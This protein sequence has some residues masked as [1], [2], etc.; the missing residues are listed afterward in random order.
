M[1]SKSNRWH[2]NWSF[3]MS[4]DDNFFL[5][6]P[7]SLLSYQIHFWFS[8]RQQCIF[9][10][11]FFLAIRGIFFSMLLSDKHKGEKKEFDCKAV[12]K[13]KLTIN[14]TSASISCA[15]ELTGLSFLLPTYA[16]SIH[17]ARSPS[18]LN[19][20]QI[21]CPRRKKMQLSQLQVPDRFFITW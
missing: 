9:I 7:S 19:L 1:R 20:Q 10:P 6:F 3:R 11:F 5:H 2:K 8:T 17:F 12:C 15:C 21:V 4:S 14:Y 16:A 18:T 13:Q